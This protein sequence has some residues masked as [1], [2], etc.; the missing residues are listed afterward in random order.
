MN[1]GKDTREVFEKKTKCK[2]GDDGRE[3]V[4]EMKKKKIQ[5]VEIKNLRR[6][7]I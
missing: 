1:L 2:A 7:N 4:E 6:I 3:F 5:K